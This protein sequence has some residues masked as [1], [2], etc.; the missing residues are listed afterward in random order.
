MPP[1]I[2][3]GTPSIEY[4]EP[5]LRW[6]D[7]CP[8]EEI[9]GACWEVYLDFR[10][11]LAASDPSGVGFV[12]VHMVHEVNAQRYFKRYWGT[13]QTKDSSGRYEMSGAMVVHVPP[14]Q[15]LELGVYELCA[16]DKSNNE[17][18]VLPAKGRSLE[19]TG[20]TS[21]KPH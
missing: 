5:L 15:R 12:G 2:D 17:G 4:F 19:W 18:C 16:R 1:Q 10:L 3:K 8:N 7:Q 13:A 21:L 9:S 11:K 20:Q 14:G 6:K